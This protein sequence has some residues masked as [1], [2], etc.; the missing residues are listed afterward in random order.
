MSLRY[1]RPTTRSNPLSHPKAYI[2]APPP[3]E[4]RL[5]Q[6][7]LPPPNLVFLP[8]PT[9]KRLPVPRRTSSLLEIFG[10]GFDLETAQGPPRKC[11]AVSFLANEVSDL[12]IGKPA[13]RSLPFSAAA[14][15]LAAA[16]R[17][18]ARSGAAA[19]VA[20]TGPARAVV[21][22]VGLADVLCFLCTDPEALARPAAVFS[23]PVS[24]LLPKDG[25][26]EVRRVDPRSR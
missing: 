25:A 13:V 24:A 10:R 17:R 9:K 6:K 3:N 26:G 23:K 15:D 19:C 11:M 18:V 14:G 16:L 4:P 7:S 21:G 1:P 5:K 12:C 2:N 8:N 20:V 22:R